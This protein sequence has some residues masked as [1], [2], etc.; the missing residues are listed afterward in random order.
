MPE[1][2]GNLKVGGDLSLSNNQLT[3]LPES[4]GNLKVGGDLYLGNNQLTSLPESFGNLKVGGGLYLSYNQLTKIP[5]IPRLI[6]DIIES[7]WCFIDQILREVVSKKT[8]KGLTIIKTPFDFVVGQDGL[9]A[10]GETVKEATEDLQFKKF[11]R[12]PEELKNFNLDKEITLGEAVNIYRAVTRSCQAGCRQ[13]L[14]GHKLPNKLTLRQGITLIGDAY[15]S[16]RFKEFF[17]VKP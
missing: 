2:F 13:F 3:S 10:H 6:G 12:D 17:G 7:D 4:F 14:A 16:D 1:S 11:D 9:W 8:I 15:G 5:K